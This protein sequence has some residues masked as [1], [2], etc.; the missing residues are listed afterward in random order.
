MRIQTK[1]KR[2]PRKESKP[3]SII[4]YTLVAILLVVVVWLNIV[5]S[6]T[7]KS[8]TQQNDSLQPPS[9]PEKLEDRKSEAKIEEVALN[10]GEVTIKT[11]NGSVLPSAKALL[12]RP[13]PYGDSQV[14]FFSDTMI[15]SPNTVVTAY[16]RVPSKFHAGKYDEWMRNILSL[17]DA[18]I[19][20]TSDD[21]VDQVKDMRQHALDRTVIV[22]L[23]LN[24]LPYGTLY[25]KEFWEDQLKRDPEK[26]THRS[27]QLFWIW[28][29]KSWFVN[30]AIRLNVFQSDIFMW[31]DIGC[32]RM[33]RYN[34]KT[35]IQHREIV[36]PKEMLQMAHH[37]PNPP[38]EDIFNDKYRRRDNFYHSGSQSVAYKDTWIK[39]HEYFLETIDRFLEK[40]MIVVEDQAILQSVCL[41]H[42]EICVYIPFT[43]VRD[44]HYFGLRYLVHYGGDF[45]FWRYDKAATTT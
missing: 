43:E 13:P 44:N 20:F 11:P 38:E 16:H 12:S 37:K 2:K 31:S 19:I 9:Q 39:F 21:M 5:V 35:M 27:Y 1:F 41:T 17:Q 10:D 45:K 29:S 6:K 34:S 25:P 3:I 28:L 18:M 7:G 14:R 30:E 26:R 36:P 23:E 40:D 33:K 32:F 8:S 4:I 15:D 42:P 24:D 22:T